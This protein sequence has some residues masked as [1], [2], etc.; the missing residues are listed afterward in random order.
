MREEVVPACWTNDFN[1]AVVVKPLGRS[2]GHNFLTSRI[3]VELCTVPPISKYKI[4]C[5]DIISMIYM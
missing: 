5:I 1:P 2:D 4:L 3:N